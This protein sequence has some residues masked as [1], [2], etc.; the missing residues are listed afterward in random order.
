MNELDRWQRAQPLFAAA[1]D[2]PPE[3]R[4]A[5][6]QET[7][8]NDP[9]LRG[10][11]SRLLAAYDEAGDSFLFTNDRTSMWPLADLAVK[12]ELNAQSLTHQ[13]PD[14][15]HSTM[16]GRT[17][18]RFRITGL[19]G[20]GGMGVVYEAV[21][22]KPLR[23]VALKVMRRGLYSRH[24][25]RRFAYEAE[26]L[27]RLNHP[28]IAQI[29]EAGSADAG[30]GGQPYFAMEL[31]EGPSL[32][33][34]AREKAL[35]VTAKLH[36]FLKVCDAVQHA[37][38]K[39]IVHRDLKPANILVVEPDE[40]DRERRAV[41]QPK[42]L[43]FGIASA[44]DSDMQMTTLGARLST[45]IGTVIYMSPEQIRGESTAVD[46]RCD[47]Y[48]LGV[49]LYELLT[50]RLPFDLRGKPLHEAMR[51][52]AETTPPLIASID[53]RLRGDLCTI[54]R[55]AMEKQPD[56][57]YASAAALAEDI[58]R[59]LNNEPIAAR[60]PSV[61]YQL[62]RFIRRNRVLSA[63]AALLGLLLLA[64]AFMTNQA[65]MT[66]IAVREEAEKQYEEARRMSNFF[67]RDVVTRLNRVPGSTEIRRDLIDEILN[68]TRGFVNA[69]PNDPQL[70]DDFAKSLR[71]RAF[72][73]DT[74]NAAVMRQHLQEI[75][76]LRERIVDLSPATLDYWME[77][78]ESYTQLGDF[79]DLSDDRKRQLEL[80]HKTLEIDQ[81]LVEQDPHSR[82]YRDNLFWSHHR[83]S[84]VHG[85]RGD[86]QPEQDWARRALAIAEELGRQYP[87]HY[88]TSYALSAGHYR[89]GSCLQRVA[90]PE[91][92]EH[93]AKALDHAEQLNA[94][95][96]GAWHF[97]RHTIEVARDTGAAAL[98]TGDRTAAI[99]AFT[100]ML[101]AAEELHRAEPEV[102]AWRRAVDLAG[103]HLSQLHT[104]VQ[105]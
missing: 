27:G 48:A 44:T 2:L 65:R 94:R 104:V 16:I 31:I 74:S 57:R 41:A 30:E 37:H 70:L 28:G 42:I 32:V 53:S 66:E 85:W 47:V 23:R 52:V 12:G 80:N 60:P 40:H 90:D 97:L 58:Y 25:M 39:G 71:A 49:V 95:Y 3:S 14:E 62:S 93:L 99:R 55:K 88:L 77:L 19:L 38:Q 61:L 29:I 78:G 59:H 7:C 100:V 86:V 75:V 101:T 102:S 17:M 56:R 21:Q 89:V 69:R 22:E 11:V 82:R 6:L 103:M 79:V 87:E 4:D 45:V 64:F 46:A 92:I 35:D 76:E 24:A 8:G 15:D 1:V 5:F 33:R 9:D 63:A 96:P 36:L 98:E 105:E 51:T 68:Q 50:G 34:Y 26:L 91:A 81:W 13:E 73:G 84:R 43:D 54:V 10:H 18:G 72:L 67:L 20:S 83:I